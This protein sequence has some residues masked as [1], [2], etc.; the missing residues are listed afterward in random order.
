MPRDLS[1][2]FYI[3]PD[4][5]V[6]GREFISRHPQEPRPLEV[7]RHWYRFRIWGRTAYSPELG[8]EYWQDQLTLRFPGVDA[9]QLYRTWKASSEIISLVDKI[10]FR[11]NDYQFCPEGCFDRDGFHDVDDFIRVAAMP[12]QGVISIS[13]YAKYGDSLAGITP[14]EIADRLDSAADV[15]ITGAASLGTGHNAEL[16]ETLG[17]FRAL[18]YLGHYYAR[19]VRGSVYTAMYRRNGN[20]RDRENAVRV[21][22]QAVTMWQDYALVSDSLYFPQL[23]ARTRKL[24]WDALLEDVRR[25]V[26]IARHARPGESIEIEFDN[27]LWNRDATRF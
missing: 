19:K 11:Q 17:D 1:P 24:D 22:E 25:D 4:G 21:L 7:E 6:W 9:E 13:D 10:H 12:V 5:Y 2:G 23:F 14:F 16:K 8:P 18:G 3:G 26:D 27:I 15:L 20:E